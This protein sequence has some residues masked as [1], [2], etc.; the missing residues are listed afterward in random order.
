MQRENDYQTR[1]AV[2]ESQFAEMKRQQEDMALD[3]KKVLS[4]LSEAKGGWRVM[5]MIGGSAGLVGAFIGKWIG[6]IVTA[7]PK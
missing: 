7:L 1:V 6:P 5:M 4:A 3:V 2:L